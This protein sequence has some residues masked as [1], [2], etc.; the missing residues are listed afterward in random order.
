MDVFEPLPSYAMRFGGRITVEI[1]HTDDPDR[2]IADTGLK[3]FEVERGPDAGK[4]MVV[5]TAG[6]A[7]VTVTFMPQVSDVTPA[8][9]SAWSEL[10]AFL[11]Q[12]EPSLVPSGQQVSDT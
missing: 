5:A 10:T 3:Q 12:L 7:N 9:Q 2:G 1:A 8:V 6:R 11:A 4:L